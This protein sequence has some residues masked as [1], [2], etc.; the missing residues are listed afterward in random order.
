MQLEDLNTPFPTLPSMTN[1]TIAW[2]TTFRKLL[3]SN[4]VIENKGMTANRSLL[5]DQFQYR[6]LKEIS[7]FMKT[8]IDSKKVSIDPSYQHIPY[9]NQSL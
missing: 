7:I 3:L 9:T 2:E 5:I 6:T 4:S 1:I 8:G